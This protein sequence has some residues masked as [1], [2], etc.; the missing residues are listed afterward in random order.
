M[1]TFGCECLQVIQN[2]I[3]Q[4]SRY[5]ESN[6]QAQICTKGRFGTM[7]FIGLAKIHD[8]KHLKGL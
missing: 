7:G 5:L 6:Q 3:L 4:V 2:C 8:K 1:N